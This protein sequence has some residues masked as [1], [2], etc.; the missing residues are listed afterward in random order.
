MVFYRFFFVFSDEVE[1]K[2]F[3]GLLVE[4]RKK[5][6]KRLTI[7][8]VLTALTSSASPCAADSAWSTLERCE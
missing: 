4:R 6:R 7:R 5:E 3:A 8:T 2:G 1:K